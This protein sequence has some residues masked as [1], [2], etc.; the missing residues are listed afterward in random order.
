VT[1]EKN[2]PRLFAENLDRCKGAGNT[3]KNM[4]T[5]EL[6]Q[7]NLEREAA[8]SA[9][10]ALQSDLKRANKA[11]EESITTFAALRERN[12]QLER[13]LAEAKDKIQSQVARIKYLEGA[14]NHATGTPLTKALKQLAEIK[15]DRD[16]W[17]AV[18]EGRL[19]DSI[20][21]VAQL[22]LELAEAREYA[23]KLAEG[24]PDGMLPKDVEVLRESNLG[25]ATELT[26]V[27]E[28]RE[29]LAEAL[30]TVVEVAR[31]NLDRPH[32]T[33]E[34]VYTKALAAVKGEK[35]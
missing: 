8:K 2:K 14:T 13:E 7:Q 30:E 16:E 24:L 15:I 21:K 28:Q 20:D 9:I 33:I 11:I 32:P 18:S 4:N 29:T 17:K 23:D 35:P 26:T 25:L 10:N 27:T 3:L 34:R 6:L 1:D 12:E 22:E 5:D 31:R 19:L